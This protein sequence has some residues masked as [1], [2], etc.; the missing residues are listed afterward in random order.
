MCKELKHVSFEAIKIERN[1]VSEGRV[2]GEIKISPFILIHKG[3]GA[4]PLSFYGSELESIETNSFVLAIGEKARTR[5]L[6]PLV[7]DSEDVLSVKNFESLRS[8]IGRLA[9][10]IAQ[11]TLE[12]TGLPLNVNV[13]I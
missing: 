2:S 8:I 11:R 10:Y 4:Q 13:H 5:E 12:N 3:E 1:L 9:F 6:T 7:K